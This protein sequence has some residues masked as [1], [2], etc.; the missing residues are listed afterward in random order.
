MY[1][2]SIIFY[3]YYYIFFYSVVVDDD[4]Y[5]DNIICGAD[6]CRRRHTRACKMSSS[7][8]TLFCSDKFCQMIR[9]FAKINAPHYAAVHQAGGRLTSCI[10]G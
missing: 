8:I 2:L 10:A 1:Y 9:S 4:R 7:A 5:D 6:S 3:Y